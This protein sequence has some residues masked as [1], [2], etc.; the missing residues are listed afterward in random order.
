MIFEDKY[1]HIYFEKVNNNIQNVVHLDN[2]FNAL[3]LHGHQFN[4]SQD[5]NKQVVGLL[6]NYLY[7][8]IK[9]NGVFFGHIHEASISDIASRSSSLCGGNSY[10]TN[11]LLLIS[12]A[13]QNLYIVNEDLSYDGVK[14]DLQNVDNIE[15]YNIVKELERYNISD[16]LGYNNEVTIK[17][18][19]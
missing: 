7:R 11:D 2:G 1:K 18:L 8:G 13:S 14:I 16:K 9:I 3:L 5:I 4:K 15:G 19:V 10:S 6:Q 12:R 17:N